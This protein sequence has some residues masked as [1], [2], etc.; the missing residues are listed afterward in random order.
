MK[1]KITVVAYI[2]H[3][4]DLYLNQRRPFMRTYADLCERS[5][6]IGSAHSRQVYFNGPNYGSGQGS[7]AYGGAMQANPAQQMLPTS[8]PHQY[9]FQSFQRNRYGYNR[10]MRAPVA[11][12]PQYI[13]PQKTDESVDNAST[14]GNNNGA[15]ARKL[16][17]MDPDVS[18]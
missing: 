12:G 10:G 11:Q 7:Q 5:Y 16:G 17:V 14:T 9:G 15:D 6:R 13:N 4:F 2:A 3:I 18:N 8:Q 1:N